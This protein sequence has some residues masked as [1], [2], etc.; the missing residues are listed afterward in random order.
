MPTCMCTGQCRKPPYTCNGQPAPG[1]LTDRQ[2]QQHQ[3]FYE[4]GDTQF[5]YPFEPWV[6]NSWAEGLDKTGGREKAERFGKNL[7]DAANI[8]NDPSLSLNEKI[9]KIQELSKTKRNR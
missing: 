7:T 1:Y 5:A 6:V 4:Q 9:T 3:K 2:R 8:A